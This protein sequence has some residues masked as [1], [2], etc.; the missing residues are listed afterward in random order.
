MIVLTR[1]Q[2]GHELRKLCDSAKARLWI[3]SPYV[4]E[5]KAVKRLLGRSWWDREIDVRLLVDADEQQVNRTTASRF[6]VKGL[7]KTLRGV[8]AKMYIVDDHVLLTSANLTYTAFARRYEAGVVLGG[9]AAITAATLF[10]S[11]WNK[12]K[13]L[14]SESISNLPQQQDAG[15]GSSL[16]LPPPTELPSDIG[17]FGRGSQVF[18]ATFG[19]YP[20]FLR[21]YSDLARIYESIG[22]IWPDV[23]LFLETDGFLDYL[24]HHDRKPSKTFTDR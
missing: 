24:Y 22:R 7:I 6:A 19:D 21:C 8:H 12:A 17:D 5:W 23:P 20:Q 11:W 13:E 1:P 3:A 10:E 2:L 16:G 4:G 18:L 14:S 9:D 15:G